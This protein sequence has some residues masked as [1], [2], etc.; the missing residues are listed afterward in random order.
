VTFTLLAVDAETRGC[1]PDP[2]YACGLT[3]TQVR[4]SSKGCD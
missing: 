2:K 4:P 3:K 1:T